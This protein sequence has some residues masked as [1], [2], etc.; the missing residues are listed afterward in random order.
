MEKDFSQ[1]NFRVNCS[2]SWANLVTVKQDD[3]EATKK[4]LADL[5]RMHRGSIRFKAM[6]AEG[7]VIEEYSSVPPAGIPLWHE[8]KRRG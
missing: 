5:A 4:A 6:D 2:G 7:G 8:P 3:Y 1:V